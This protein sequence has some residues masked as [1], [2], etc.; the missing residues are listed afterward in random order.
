LKITIPP[1][2]FA[3]NVEDEIAGRQYQRSKTFNEVEEALAHARS[4]ILNPGEKVS[5]FA[6]N[7]TD[8]EIETIKRA[9]Y[10]LRT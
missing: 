8:E 1:W 7:H 6:S 2:R 4:I 9:G 10:E 3:V 5:I